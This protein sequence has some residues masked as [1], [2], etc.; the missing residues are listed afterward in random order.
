LA[1]IFAKLSLF[2]LHVRTTDCAEEDGTLHRQFVK[3][4]TELQRPCIPLP[5]QQMVK[6]KGGFGFSW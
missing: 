3:K 4:T 2:K 6:E 1:K 5:K